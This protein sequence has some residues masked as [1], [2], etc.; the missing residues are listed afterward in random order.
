LLDDGI[1][2]GRQL[3]GG[4]V[5]LHLALLV[6]LLTGLLIAAAIWLNLSR[7]ASAQQPVGSL[8]K[9]SKRPKLKQ[10]VDL[11]ASDFDRHPVWV[12]THSVD[13]DEPWYDDDDV[14]EETFR[15]WTKKMPVSPDDGMF[16]VRASF[17]TGDGVRYAGFLT[18]SARDDVGDLQPTILI[19]PRHVALWQGSVP[20]RALHR[21]SFYTALGKTADQL[22]PIR[23]TADP[24]LANG[25]VSGQAEGFYGLDDDWS[26]VVER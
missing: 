6:L 20:G 16:L 11:E 7:S 21:Q 13:Y 25:V 18:P 2:T 4:E 24:G 12:S 1:V 3:R 8:A 17:T 19:G 5:K 9:R 15:P 14:D 22:F 23:F 26:V 10:F